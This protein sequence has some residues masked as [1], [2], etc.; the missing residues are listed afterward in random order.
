MF[1]LF[2]GGYNIGIE[3][4]KNKISQ[5]TQINALLEIAIELKRDIGL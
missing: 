3:A 1:S 2:G 4:A 5:L